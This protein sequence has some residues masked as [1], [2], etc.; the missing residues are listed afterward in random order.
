MLDK[1]WI[2][3]LTPKQQTRYQTFTDCS[4]CP[5]LGSFKKCNT[6]KF[7]HKATT[8]EYIED[9]HKVFLDSI[10]YN[11]ASFVQYVKYGAMN[12]TDTSKM[13][14]YMISPWFCKPDSLFDD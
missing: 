6:I 9:I 10:S 1:P 14:Y 2:R 4:Y 12:T 13:L 3:G 7:S 8:G 5:V 11:M